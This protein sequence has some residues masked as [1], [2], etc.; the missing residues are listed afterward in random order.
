MTEGKT[1]EP[2]AVR[3]EGAKTCQGPVC[4]LYTPLGLAMFLVGFMTVFYAPRPYKIIGW[5]VVILAYIKGFFGVR[6]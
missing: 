5:V 2:E 3:P 1:T 4:P 6:D